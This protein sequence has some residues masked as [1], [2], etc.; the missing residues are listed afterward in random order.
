MKT[1]MP[2][3]VIS[4]SRPIPCVSVMPTYNANRT[5][6]QPIASRLFA[7]KNTQM[8]VSDV[9]PGSHQDVLDVE[10]VPQR[11]LHDHADHGDEQ[12]PR[13]PEAH[14]SPRLKDLFAAAGKRRP[15]VACGPAPDPPI[16]SDVADH[17]VGADHGQSE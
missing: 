7:R 16:E 3:P 10:G 12:K 8:L 15:G 2:T 14:R 5:S 1:R 17:K 9:Y 4:N 6:T 13:D 11:H